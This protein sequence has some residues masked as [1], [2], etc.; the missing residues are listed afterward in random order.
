MFFKMN[1]SE[2]DPQKVAK[3]GDFDPKKPVFEHFS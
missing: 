2:K 1:G 3:M